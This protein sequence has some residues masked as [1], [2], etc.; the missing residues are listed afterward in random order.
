MT[1]HKSLQKLEVEKKL[2]WEISTEP[3]RFQASVAHSA[4]RK[5]LVGVKIINAQRAAAAVP[6][7]G[8]GWRTDVERVA[9]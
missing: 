7:Q 5:K 4:D 1:L 2:G 8:F 6:A 3:R 9:A